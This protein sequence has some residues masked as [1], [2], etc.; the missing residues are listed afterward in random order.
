MEA[1]HPL[2][3]PEVINLLKLKAAELGQ[4]VTT[5]Q[6]TAVMQAAIWMQQKLAAK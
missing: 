5:E 2:L 4:T 3:K 1:N 6:V